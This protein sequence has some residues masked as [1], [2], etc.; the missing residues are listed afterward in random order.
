M[1]STILFFTMCLTMGVE[2]DRYSDCSFNWYLLND[3]IF[4]GM[5]NLFQVAEDT[6]AAEDVAGFMVSSEELIFVRNE[7]GW[8]KILIHE[9]KHA[10]C[11]L[12]FDI[13]NIDG[14]F[15]YI[16]QRVLCDFVV[17]LPTMTAGSKE[18]EQIDARGPNK[19]PI[20]DKNPKL[21]FQE[22]MY[23]NQYVTLDR[24]VTEQ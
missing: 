3:E 6:P 4:D 21:A 9:S 19:I 22:L 2:D 24:I 15:D 11:K 7:T 13:D 20:P 10:K 23:S 12:Q 1:I 5:Y 17:D 8:K 16:W 18:L 14:A